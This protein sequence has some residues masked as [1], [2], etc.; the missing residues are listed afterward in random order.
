MPGKIPVK[1]LD[2]HR[3]IRQA[4]ESGVVLFVENRTV[5]AYPINK[6]SKKLRQDVMDLHAYVRELLILAVL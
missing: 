2:A 6:L 3:V 4:R 1:L 5:Y